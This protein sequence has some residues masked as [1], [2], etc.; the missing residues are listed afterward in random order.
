MEFRSKFKAVCKKIWQG[1]KSWR[2]KGMWFRLTVLLIIFSVPLYE[3]LITKNHVPLINEF[4]WIACRAIRAASE[5]RVISAHL[6]YLH[7]Q[8]SRQLQSQLREKVQNGNLR[9]NTD[10]MKLLNANTLNA[11]YNKLFELAKRTGIIPANISLRQTKR[12]MLDTSIKL[13]D[14]RFAAEWDDV[15]KRTLK[16]YPFRLDVLIMKFKMLGNGLLLVF[17]FPLIPALPWLILCLSLGM[18]GTNSKTKVKFSLFTAL[19]V[20][21]TWIWLYFSSYISSNWEGWRAIGKWTFL[22]TT[23]FLSIWAVIGSIIGR[24][25]YK[26]ASSYSKETQLLI[27]LLLISGIILLMPTTLFINR[28]YYSWWNW[29]VYYPAGRLFFKNSNF[30]PYFS[31]IGVG[32]LFYTLFLI[33]KTYA[34]KLDKNKW[35]LS[36]KYLVIVLLLAKL[37]YAWYPLLK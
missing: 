19:A 8:K 14:E 37:V 25:L 34:Q 17:P 21:M 23:I 4:V 29:W 3:R 13:T 31:T 30:A 33:F 35:A 27:S 22:G 18:C 11:N 10:E 24:R 6:R 20:I 12:A 9:L 2:K 16:E 5:P 15:K 1:F 36:A 26:Y 7:V 28:N 32:V